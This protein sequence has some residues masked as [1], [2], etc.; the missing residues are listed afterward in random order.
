M[1][2]DFAKMVDGYNAKGACSGQLYFQWFFSRE[3]FLAELA[4]PT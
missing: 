4:V 2:N 1:A 3:H